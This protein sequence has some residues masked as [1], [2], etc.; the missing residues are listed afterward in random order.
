[1]NRFA[2]AIL[3]LFV[4]LGLLTGPVTGQDFAQAPFRTAQT[5][6][7]T[8]VVTVEAPDVDH[9]T[10][11]FPAGAVGACTVFTQQVQQATSQD[12]P[13]GKYA[14]RHCWMIT[15]TTTGYPDDWDY[16]RTPWD[17]HVEVQYP[18]PSGETEFVRSNTVR[19]WR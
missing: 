11:A 3:T 4:T 5:P 2:L 14:P 6:P 19:V 10:V 7:G 9:L 17:V 13:D 16:I 12:W 1:M 8:R 15:E 18:L